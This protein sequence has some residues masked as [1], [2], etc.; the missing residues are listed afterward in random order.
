MPAKPKRIPGRSP[1]DMLFDRATPETKQ[2]FQQFKSLKRAEDRAAFMK[3]TGKAPQ[4]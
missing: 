4:P 1:M 2:V 3:R